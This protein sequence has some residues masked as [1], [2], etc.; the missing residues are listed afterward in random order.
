MPLLNGDHVTD[1][2]GTGFVHTAPGHGAEDFDIW[3]ASKAMLEAR[4]ISSKIPYTVDGDGFYT[5]ERRASK[6]AG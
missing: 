6:V 3:M 5:R 4:G 2:A 1:D